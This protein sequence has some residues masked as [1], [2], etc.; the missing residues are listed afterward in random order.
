MAS[1]HKLC[2][3]QHNAC[4]KGVGCKGSCFPRFDLPTPLQT[5]LTLNVD[6]KVLTGKC[7]GF[8]NQNLRIISQSTK[9]TWYM[10]GGTILQIWIHRKLD[11]LNI[12]KYA[13]K[14]QYI[15]H[16][17][18][19]LAPWNTEMFL[20]SKCGFQVKILWH[21][22]YTRKGNNIKKTYS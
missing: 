21:L 1:H 13:L 19:S 6:I 4:R 9:L 18:L 7:S 11:S 12:Y 22:A 16:S 8:C 14:I 2:C 3:Y 15:D 10:G 17:H 5:P 20:N